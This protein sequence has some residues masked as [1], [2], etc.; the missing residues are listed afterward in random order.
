MLV[1]QTRHFH[2]V[3]ESWIF[4][5]LFVV[6]MGLLGVDNCPW[7]DER[8]CHVLRRKTCRQMEIDFDCDARVKSTFTG[9]RICGDLSCVF[10]SWATRDNFQRT[11][12]E[13][14]SIASLSET[15]E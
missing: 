12:S 9:R 8:H 1:F 4:Y 13:S 14:D 11:S 10:P 2:V 7:G 15:P 6:V 3:V 5:I